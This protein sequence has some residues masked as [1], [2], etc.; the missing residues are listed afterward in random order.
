M[1]TEDAAL[2][3]WELAAQREALTLGRIPPRREACFRMLGSVSL[4]APVARVRS[5]L[6]LVVALMAALGAL[7]LVAARADAVPLAG[8][9][10]PLPG[11]MFEGGDGNQAAALP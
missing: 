9:A 8:S 2:P 5:S 7:A 10:N 6:V 3:G 4:V 1:R 11:S